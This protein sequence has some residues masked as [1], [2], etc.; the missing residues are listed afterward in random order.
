MGTGIKKRRGVYGCWRHRGNVRYARGQG[1]SNT[2]RLKPLATLTG[3]RSTTGLGTAST[4]LGGKHA[5][6][7][8]IAEC[9]QKKVVSDV[10]LT[11]FWS[12]LIKG[13]IDSA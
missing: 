10:E 13:K 7:R 1:W 11:A 8:A 9:R 6:S 5:Y 12:M 3:A 4:V 2:I